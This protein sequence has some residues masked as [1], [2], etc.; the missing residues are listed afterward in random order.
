L[1]EAPDRSPR[2]FQVVGDHL[3]ARPITVVG[4]AGDD[5]AVTGL[6]EGDRVVVSTFLGWATLSSGL[7]VEVIQ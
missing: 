6:A 2:V 3:E 4:D 7:R 1:V 5:L